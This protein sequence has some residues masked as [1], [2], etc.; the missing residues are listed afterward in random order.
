LTN[1]KFIKVGIIKILKKLF[2]KKNKSNEN[3]RLFLI[4]VDPKKKNMGVGA[5]LIKK[6]EEDIN[7]DGHTSYGLYVRTNNLNAIDFYLNRGFTKEFKKFD[8]YSFT[9]KLS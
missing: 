9:K 4:G 7:C 5:R 3:L 8:L 2:S 1:P 6:F